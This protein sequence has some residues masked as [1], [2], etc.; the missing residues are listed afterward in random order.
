MR[1][2]EQL[3]EDVVDELGF[4]PALNETGI[5]VAVDDNVVTLSGHVR[6]YAEKLAAERAAKRVEGVH[7][8]ASEPGVTGVAN[9]LTIGAGAMAGT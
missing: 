8:L 2:P 9:Q 3:R 4:E 5:G 7:G 6:S 1:T